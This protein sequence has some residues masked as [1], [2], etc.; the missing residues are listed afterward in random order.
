MRGFMIQTLQTAKK[1][2]LILVTTILLFTGIVV[3]Q[4]VQAKADM[5]LPNQWGKM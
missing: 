3:V 1:L 5:A 2:I 4:P